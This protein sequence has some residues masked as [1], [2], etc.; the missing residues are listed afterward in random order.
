M[1]LY[2]IGS[3]WMKAVS[4]LLGCTGCRGVTTQYVIHAMLDS[5][6]KAR[7]LHS[8]CNM[9][10]LH[11]VCN[12]C[13]LDSVCNICCVHTC[14]HLSLGSLLQHLASQFK[15]EIDAERSSSFLFF[16]FL[17]F[18]HLRTGYWYVCMSVLAYRVEPS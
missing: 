16:L 17:F 3:T 18:R 2:A 10:D 7:D 9:C 4:F 11:S 12:T 1:S 13:D 14:R 6:C 8:V 5:V 15:A